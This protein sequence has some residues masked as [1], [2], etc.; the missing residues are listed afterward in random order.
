[1]IKNDS[2][3]T[4]SLCLRKTSKINGHKQLGKPSAIKWINSNT[5]NYVLGVRKETVHIAQD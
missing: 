2:I 3:S 1:M 4:E 5:S